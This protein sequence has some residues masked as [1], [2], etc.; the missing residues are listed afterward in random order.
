MEP[1]CI[2]VEIVFARPDRTC[3][4]TLTLASGATVADA[5]DRAAQSA[6]FAEVHWG[7]AALGI[8]GRMVDRAQVLRPGDRLEIYR[9]LAADPKTAR[10][11][12]VA[13][14]SGRS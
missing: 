11:K 12:R 2:Q 4:L 8:F 5:V 1:R 13:S 3:S 9:P 7:A 14:K 10:R 6:E